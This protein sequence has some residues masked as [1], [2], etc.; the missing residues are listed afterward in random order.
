MSKG[1]EVLKFLLDKAKVSSQQL[2]CEK[3]ISGG[4]SH[5]VEREQQG[6]IFIYNPDGFEEPTGTTA[7]LILLHRHSAAF[8]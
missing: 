5:S 1:L 2:H 4:V 6:K 7:N 8:R 3:E